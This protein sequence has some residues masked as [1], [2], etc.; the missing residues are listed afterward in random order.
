MPGLD[1][2][3]TLRAN[4]AER[5]GTEASDWYPTFRTRHAMQAVFEALR[6]HRGAGEVVTQ[7][8][9]C[10]TAVDPIIASGM[11]PR[12]G[13]IDA[14]TLAL[15]ACAL[16]LSEASRAVMLQHTFGLFDQAADQALVDAAHAAGVLALEDSAHCACHLSR[17]ADGTPLADVSFH[18]FGVQKM[19]S[20]DFGA[21]TWINPHM[22]DQGL[23]QALVDALTTLPA[24]DRRLDRAARG[25]DFQIRVL[26]HLP[27]AVRHALWDRLARWR[28]F[29]PSVSSEER[30]GRV[31]YEPSLPSAW[32]T[33]HMMAGLA[34]LKRQEDR[35]LEATRIFARELAPLAREG[36]VHIPAAA[37]GEPRALLRF[38]L[39]LESAARADALVEAIV[40]SGCYCDTWGRPALFPGALDAQAYGLASAED[41]GAWPE[42]SRCVGGV[43]PLYTSVPPEEALSVSQTVT[44]FLKS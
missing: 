26:M 14:D 4:L 32:V 30:A 21:A 7:L 43:V 37:L 39:V 16:P 19:A 18:S 35:S 12:Y 38:P 41:L 29:I 22:E 25:Y 9:T 8:L 2:F 10:C 11:T 13:D 3:E 31:S 20:S 6:A 1:G 27:A 33:E 34:D 44:S 24:F 23:Y 28:V 40:A 5:T 36:L 17:G 15:D 42:T